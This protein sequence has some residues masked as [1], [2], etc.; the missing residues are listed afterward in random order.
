METSVPASP[1]SHKIHDAFFRVP[2][3]APATVLPYENKTI[4]SACAL[5]IHKSLTIAKVL[6][7]FCC[8]FSCS[9]RLKTPDR[10]GVRGYLGRN[11]AEALLYSKNDRGAAPFLRS[12][13]RIRPQSQSPMN[14]DPV[15][16][17]FFPCPSVRSEREMVPPSQL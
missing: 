14:R 2:G 10:R 6:L 16:A 4:P 13:E 9:H 11:I 3:G 12:V 15:C 1:R 7:N 8:N 5:S 17:L